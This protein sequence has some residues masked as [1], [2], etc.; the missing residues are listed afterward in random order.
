MA[1]TLCLTHS[2]RAV[3]QHVPDLGDEAFAGSDRRSEQFE[4]LRLIIGIDDVLD[5]LPQQLGR[6]TLND[7]AK[8]VVDEHEPPGRI[9][10]RDADD[11][12]AEHGAQILLLLA[13]PRLDAFARRHV[14]AQRE[15]RNGAPIMNTISSRKDSSRSRPRK[16]RR[17]PASPDRKARQ[18]QRGCC[19][20]ARAA[21][22]RGPQQRHD[23]KEAQRAPDDR[24]LDQR[25]EGDQADGESPRSMQWRTCRPPGVEGADIADRPKHEDRRNHERP[26]HVAQPPRDPEG[27]EA[28]PVGVTGHAQ[29]DHADG[30]ADHRAGPEAD[31]RK[32]GDAGRRVEG[33]ATIGPDVDQIA[34]RERRKRVARRDRR[35]ACIEPRSRRPYRSSRW[36]PTPPRKSPAKSA[37]PRNSTAAKAKPA[38]SQ[39]GIALGW[40]AASAK[41]TLASTK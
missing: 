28:R 38:G 8:S 3:R 14:G 1:E 32:L 15:T 35:G 4:H 9:D 16:G 37:K 40:S 5:A 11:R 34:G 13:Q 24:L 27:D 22:Q 30:C 33:S 31:Q 41:P 23:G 39:I 26:H 10:L 17:P 18:D 25:T 12:L 20:V 2:A 21:T 7:L 19:G 6:R 29:A 36:R